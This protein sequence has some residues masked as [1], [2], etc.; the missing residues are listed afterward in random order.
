MCIELMMNRGNDDASASVLFSSVHFSTTSGTYGAHSGSGPFVPWFV[1]FLGLFPGG[2]RPFRVP[3][4][5]S[6]SNY[7]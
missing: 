3:L 6:T 4:V 1:I 2:V 7:V 5:P